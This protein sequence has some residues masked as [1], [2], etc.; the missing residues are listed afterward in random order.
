MN[1]EETAQ[2]LDKLADQ[3]SHS[4]T[5]LND[6]LE[7][8]RPRLLRLVNLR[9]PEG[10]GRRVAAEDIVQ[11]TLASASKR[12]S[13]FARRRQVP[14]FVWLRGL[15][16]ERLIDAQRKH[17]QAQKRDVARETNPQDWLSESSRQMTDVWVAQIKSP[18]EFVSDK[19]RAEDLQRAIAELPQRDREVVLLRFFESLSLQETASAMES[20]INHIKVLQ[21][22]ALK[23][24]E[25]LMVERIGWKTADLKR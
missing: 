8:A 21:F 4:A 19:Q 6:L 18:S 22:R 11:E 16:I 14:V 23:K 9:M 12:F 20:S 1:S 15:A 3:A 10:L 17:L 2:I 13:D 24:L 7:V 25:K 5:A